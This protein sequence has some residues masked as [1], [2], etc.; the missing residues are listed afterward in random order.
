MPTNP[1]AELE[2][3][4]AE[5]KRRRERAAKAKDWDPYNPT[6]KEGSE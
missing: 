1:Y 5:E 2:R 6:D 4:Q 3:R